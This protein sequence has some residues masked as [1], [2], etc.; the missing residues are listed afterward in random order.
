M[1]VNVT[2]KFLIGGKRARRAFSLLPF[3]LCLYH[4][5][6]SMRRRAYIRPLLL[7]LLCLL[8]VAPPAHAQATVSPLPPP[9]GFANDY[10]NVIDAATK[11]RLETILTAGARQPRRKEAGDGV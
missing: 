7:A 4:A 1:S 10:A 3:T 6:N 8:C 9:T 5:A 11:T 2:N